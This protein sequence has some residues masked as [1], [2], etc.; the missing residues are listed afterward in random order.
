MLGEQEPWLDCRARFDVLYV[1]TELQAPCPGLL[2]IPAGYPLSGIGFDLIVVPRAVQR[3]HKD[4][5]DG[6][7]ARLNPRGRMVIVND[8]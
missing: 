6:L 4:W 3:E 2:V 7:A 8:L 5:V 1:Q